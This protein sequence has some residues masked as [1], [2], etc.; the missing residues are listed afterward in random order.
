M[1]I[2]TNYFDGKSSD[3]I[4]KATDYLNKKH[5]L[6]LIP[7]KIHTNYD[8]ISTIKELESDVEGY[9]IL[10]AM[11]AAIR[12]QKRRDKS[13]EKNVSF[14]TTKEVIDAMEYIAKK[15]KKT[16]KE[17]LSDLI[18]SARDG[19]KANLLIIK[20]DRKNSKENAQEI[21][22]LKE[23]ISNF[24]REIIELG[25]EKIKLEE[26]VS[27]YEIEVRKLK[28]GRTKTVEGE[29]RKRRILVPQKK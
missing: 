20:E 9:R 19:I 27:E 2:E 18:I 8:L 29:R 7:K 26:R 5:A 14:E 11:K 25:N 6:D 15:T 12:A 13:K 23:D 24:K 21:R 28:G 22:R 4:K 10:M 16:K 3:E 17:F 1:I